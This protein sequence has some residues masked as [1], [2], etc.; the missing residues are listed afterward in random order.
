MRIFC[1]ERVGFPNRI[2]AVMLILLFLG[3]IA[4]IATAADTDKFIKEIELKEKRT[5]DFDGMVKQKIVRVLVV[6]NKMLYF[7]DK[8][9]QR[10]VNVDMFREFEKHINQK[11]K[12]G[13]LKVHVLFIPV[14]R[15]QLLPA[16]VDGRGDIAAAN[17]TITPHRQKLVDFS[18]PL[19]SNAKEILITGPSAPPIESLDD[20]SGKEIH[21]RPS[22]SY[23]EHVLKLNERFKKEGKPPVKIV[24]ASQF[25]EDSDLLEM[26]NAGLIPMVIVDD[27]KAGFWGQIFD[28][29]TLHPGIFVNEGGKIAWAFRKNS[30]KLAAVVNEFVKT[31]KKGT[32][33]GNMM[34]KRYLKDNK[35][36]RNSLSPSESALSL[37]CVDKCGED[38]QPSKNWIGVLAFH[39]MG[40]T[41]IY[42]WSAFHNNRIG[43]SDV[44]HAF[45][46]ALFLR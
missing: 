45:F 39:N 11:L 31:S 17:L 33:L 15:D 36:A 43:L 25:L 2:A 7:L 20:L 35:W 22:S 6:F 14:P 13:T 38:Q 42:P 19:Y 41:I 32:L 40:I 46:M 34:F 4:C 44:V 26:V 9:Q 5:D 27:H 28:K 12:T 37:C 24:P 16:L 30:P 10:G 23:H 3:P 29:V 21:L 18:D 1:N 8:G